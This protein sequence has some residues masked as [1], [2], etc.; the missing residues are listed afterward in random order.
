LRARFDMQ[1]IVI[2]RIVPVVLDSIRTELAA[3]K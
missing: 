3:L 1:R 2:A